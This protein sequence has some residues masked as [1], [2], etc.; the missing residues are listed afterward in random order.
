MSGGFLSIR[1]R[2]G[3]VLAH[4]RIFSRSSASKPGDPKHAGLYIPLLAVVQEQSTLMSRGTCMHGGDLITMG[5]LESN[6]YRLFNPPACV[7]WYKFLRFRYNT[8]TYC[9]F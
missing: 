2:N 9:F 3:A 6:I 1:S 7:P 5:S 4:G 8:N